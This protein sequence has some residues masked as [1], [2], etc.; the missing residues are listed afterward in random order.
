MF[1]QFFLTFINNLRDIANRPFTDEPFVPFVMTKY[2]NPK[3]TSELLA[4]AV[5]ESRLHFKKIEQQQNNVEQIKP[6]IEI[7]TPR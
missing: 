4:D 3:Q 1:N 7:T 5:S 2:K 6:D